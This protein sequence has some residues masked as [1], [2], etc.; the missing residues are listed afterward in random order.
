[1]TRIPRKLSQATRVPAGTF[2]IVVDPVT[3]IGDSLQLTVTDPF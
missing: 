2:E 1:M 3:V